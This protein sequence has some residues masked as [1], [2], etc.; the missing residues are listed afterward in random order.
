MTSAESPEVPVLVR[1]EWCKGCGICIAMCPKKV[2]EAAA[3]GKVVVARPEDCIKCETCEIMCP[4]F[5]IRVVGGRSKE[6]ARGRED[7]ADARA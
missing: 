1:Q 2:L 5:A 4:D 3:D 7:V 6:V